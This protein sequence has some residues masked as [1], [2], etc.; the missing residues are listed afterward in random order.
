MATNAA[1]NMNTAP[2]RQPK[3][4][5]KPAQPGLRPVKKPRKNPRQA[6]REQH[7]AAVFTAKVCMV[8]LFYISL[9]AVMLYGKFQLNALS[10]E[11]SRMQQKLEVAQ[12]EGV[13]LRME[14]NSK[15]SLDKVEEY[16]VTKLGMVKKENYQGE[17][18]TIDESKAAETKGGEAKDNKA[19][20]ADK[21]ENIS[22]D[23]EKRSILSYIF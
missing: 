20:A 19:P 17:Y 21:S 8:A 15:V 1:Y 2:V 11:T 12:S 4:N 9:F 14:S 5:P 6:A 16:A 18:V 22:V 23:S 13:R 7:E 3:R 10:V